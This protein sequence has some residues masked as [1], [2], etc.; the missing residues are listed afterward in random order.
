MQNNFW[1]Y[2]KKNIIALL[3]QFINLI[4]KN[5]SKFLKLILLNWFPL[6]SCI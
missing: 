1:K 3:K 2:I 4:N 5:M 6:N